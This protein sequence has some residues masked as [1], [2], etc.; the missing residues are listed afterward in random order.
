MRFTKSRPVVNLLVANLAVRV[1]S[2]WCQPVR[3]ASEISDG[4]S[5]CFGSLMNPSCR[6]PSLRSTSGRSSAGALAAAAA[7]AVAAA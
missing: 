2:T 5:F 1:S 7:A 4:V 6:R 3:P